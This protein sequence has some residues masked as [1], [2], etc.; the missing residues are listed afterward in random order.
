MKLEIRLASISDI[1]I[2]LSFVEN[3]HAVEG[4]SVTDKQRKIALTTLLNNKTLG[5]IWLL[6]VQGQA[7]GYIVLCFGFSI[8]FGGK[9]AFIEE[10][11][12]TPE[13]RGKGLG[14]ET[15]SLIKIVAKGHGVCTLLLEVDKTKSKAQELYSQLG[16]KRRD[17]YMLM[18]AKL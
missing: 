4:I 13:F 3:F 1:Q 5:E 16:F 8:E 18:S 14:K 9:D 6:T 7:I 17:K 12:I 11:Y 2:V 15:L 10:F